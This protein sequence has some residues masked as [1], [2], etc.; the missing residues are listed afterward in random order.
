MTRGRCA[1]ASM[2]L[3]LGGS[4]SEV[5]KCCVVTQSQ[6]SDSCSASP[7]FVP[8]GDAG[9]MSHPQLGMHSRFIFVLRLTMA[10]L[11]CYAVS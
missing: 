8:S 4:N 9:L 7:R 6:H 1:V 10:L 11:L 5:L 3:P 2:V